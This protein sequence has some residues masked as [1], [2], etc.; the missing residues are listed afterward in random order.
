MGLFVGSPILASCWCF[1]ETSRVSGVW[2]F[3][4]SFWVSGLVYLGLYF[5]VWVGFYVIG[6]LTFIVLGFFCLFIFGFG[7]FYGP[8][9]L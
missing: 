2:A 1:P 3:F 4:G 5:N 6:S 9:V 7:F 8:G